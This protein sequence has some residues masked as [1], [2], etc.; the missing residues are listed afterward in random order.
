MFRSKP[1]LDFQENSVL[2]A[3]LLSGLKVVALLTLPVA[4]VG[5]VI[6]SLGSFAQIGSIFSSDP[7]KPDASRINPLQGLKAFF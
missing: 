7:L 4:L 2:F 6:G 5:M 3:T 1:R